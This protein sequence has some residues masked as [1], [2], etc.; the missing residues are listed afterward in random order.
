MFIV[1]NIFA[2]L[3]TAYFLAARFDLYQREPLGTRLTGVVVGAVLFAMAFSLS[4]WWMQRSG[5]GLEPSVRGIIAAAAL[6]A[7]PEEV[8]KFL[9]VLFIACVFK[10]SFHNDPFD[11]VVYGAL[12]GV[13][14]GLFEFGATAWR[15]GLSADSA[16]QLA[17]S[18]FG[19]PVLGGIGASALGLWRTP[20]PRSRRVMLVCGATGSLLLAISI[21]VCWN[22]LC[23]GLADKLLDHSTW[24]Q[25]LQALVMVFGLVCFAG[26][27]GTAYVVTRLYV[28]P[29]CRP[30]RVHH[31]SWEW[32][33][34]ALGPWVQRRL[35]PPT[36]SQS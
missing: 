7:V 5:L 22:L 13:G 31:D 3:T 18:S 29:A 36:A 24:T 12:V 4:A 25:I 10:R 26:A 8:S 20:T 17:A 14:A 11:G 28:D 32:A 34:R 23:F 2:L 35:G 1:L 33:L 21:H 30:R 6:T 27:C 9:G 16:A 15:E 19:H